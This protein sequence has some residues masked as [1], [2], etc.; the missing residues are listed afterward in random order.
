MPETHIT[1][2]YR[3]PT[4]QSEKLNNPREKMGKGHEQ[5]VYKK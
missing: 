2:A 4:N 1:N 5:I 3:F